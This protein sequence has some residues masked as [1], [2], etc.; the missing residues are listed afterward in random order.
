M[1]LWFSMI[2]VSFTKHLQFIIGDGL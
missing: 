1:L 2:A